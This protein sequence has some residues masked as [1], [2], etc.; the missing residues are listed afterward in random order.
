MGLES[1]RVRTCGGNR[2]GGNDRPGVLTR[3]RSRG[4]L[5]IRSLE[6]RQWI[7]LR[8]T[9]SPVAKSIPGSTGTKAGGRLLPSLVADFCHH[10][11]PGDR[12]GRCWSPGS[13]PSEHRA[14]RPWAARCSSDPS[15]RPR[16]PVPRYRSPARRERREGSGLLEGFCDLI[17]EDRGSDPHAIGL[18]AGQ[19]F[20]KVESLL[21]C[22]PGGQG[23]L[24][25]V[26][27]RLDERGLVRREGLFQGASDLV[28][29]LAMEANSSTGLGE[30]DEVDRLELG[31]S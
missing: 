13:H 29:T 27:H 6:V 15:R 24:E 16:T 22:G 26:D 14:A 10:G 21:G 30:L 2:T 12:A 28:G 7:G 5:P 23:W 17:A 1:F 3:V 25:R 8:S 20:G 19:R 31:L 9:S 4:E 11:S 18:A